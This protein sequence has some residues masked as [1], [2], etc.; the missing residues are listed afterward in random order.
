MNEKKK[1]VKITSKIEKSKNLLNKKILTN[2]NIKSNKLNKGKKEEKNI[3]IEK[4]EF[5]LEDNNKNQKKIQYL[6]NYYKAKLKKSMK[7]KNEN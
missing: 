5:I 3:P 2:S 4:F 7:I 1:E 6:N